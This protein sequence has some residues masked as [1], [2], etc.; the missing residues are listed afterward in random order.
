[1][2]QDVE[3]LDSPASNKQAFFSPH[4]SS[5][6]KIRSLIPKERKPFPLVVLPNV[7]C[8]KPWLLACEPGGDNV[9]IS[10]GGLFRPCNNRQGKPAWLLL[11]SS[12]FFNGNCSKKWNS[13][14]S[15]LTK[16]KLWP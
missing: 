3:S 4:V 7:L 15:S 16:K 1:M 10:S 6:S 8:T 9:V 12:C 14:H 2:Y 11:V 5:K 13:S